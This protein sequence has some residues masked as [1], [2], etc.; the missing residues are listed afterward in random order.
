MLRPPTWRASSRN[1]ISARFSCGRSSR[2]E[3]WRRLSIARSS[4]SGRRRRRHRGRAQR[5]EF[6]NDRETLATTRGPVAGRDTAGNGAGFR[7]EHHD[8]KYGERANSSES[9]PGK[10]RTWHR[11]SG[12]FENRICGCDRARTEI[13]PGLASRR[14]RHYFGARRALETIE[15]RTAEPD[16]EYHRDSRENKPRAKRIQ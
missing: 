5:E 15:R 6:A 11:H 13:Q 8:Y 16:H 14:T 3:A 4:V 10:R 9:L 1:R 12:S 2:R 7:A